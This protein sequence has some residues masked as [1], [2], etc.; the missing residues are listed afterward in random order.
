[1]LLLSLLHRREEPVEP[2]AV[3]TMQMGDE[4]ADDTPEVQ[5]LTA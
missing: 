5:A 1:M 4:D 2:V 3:V